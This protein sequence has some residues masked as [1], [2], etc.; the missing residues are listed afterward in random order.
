MLIELKARLG[1]EL[2]RLAHE[3]TLLVPEPSG[4]SLAEAER[5]RALERQKELQRHV[6]H[7]GQLMTGL[8]SAD[9]ETIWPDRAG[10]GSRIRLQNLTNGQ[11]V[12]YTL[13]TGEVIDIDE[14]QVS[15]GSPMG[16]AL[17]GCR[18]GDEVTVCAPQG[19]RRFRVLSVITMPQM[20]GFDTEPRSVLA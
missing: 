13:M 16:Q 5:A 2:D 8:V 6:R 4:A 12:T 18:A 10:Y 1:N 19:I 7:L 15:L 14:N 3:L 9:P 17:L 11:E 20:L